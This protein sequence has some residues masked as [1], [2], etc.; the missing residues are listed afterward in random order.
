MATELRLRAGWAAVGVGL[1]LISSPMLGTWALGQ[2]Y[3]LLSLG[4]VAAWVADRRGRLTV[5]GISLGLIVAVKPQLAPVLLWP[6]VRRRW[7]AFGAALAAGATATLA[8][9]VVAGSGA[10]L[11]WLG[12]V[13]NRRPD[14]YWD[15]NTLPG[16][17]ARLFRE[18]EFV[19]PIAILPWL[20]PVAYVLGIGIVILTA[21]KARRGS[22]A[23]CGR[24]SRL[25][26]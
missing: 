21:F 15:N 26:F 2:M 7:R 14:G 8:A 19:E 9:M 3:P 23:G 17:A 5:S 11:D 12:D 6:L 10:L 18:N 16:A 13:G 22:E 25:R 1:L 4:L 24:W 20:E